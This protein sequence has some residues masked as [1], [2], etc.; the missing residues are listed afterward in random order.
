VRLEFEP[1]LEP[2]AR[3][4]QHLHRRGGDFRPDAVAGH[5]NDS[6]ARIVSTTRTEPQ[7]PARG[8]KAPE[9]SRRAAL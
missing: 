3:A 7:F 5:D 4:P 6:H 9:E 2:V 1:E 8:R